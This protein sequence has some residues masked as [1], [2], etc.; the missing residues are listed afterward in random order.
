MNDY[1][2]GGS[3]HLSL[4]SISGDLERELLAKSWQ[5][6]WQIDS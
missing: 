6:S 1:G 5:K 3:E 2:F 4:D